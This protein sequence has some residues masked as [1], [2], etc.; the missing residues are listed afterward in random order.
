MSRATGKGK[1]SEFVIEVTDTGI[2]I[3]PEKADKLF[4][5]FVQA[6]ATTTRRFG[7]AGLGVHDCF[8]ADREPALQ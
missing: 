6:D 5:P 2:G 1:N 7:A 8:L 4:E 3:T